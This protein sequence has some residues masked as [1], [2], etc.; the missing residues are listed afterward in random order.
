MR[1]LLDPKKVNLK[2]RETPQK[3][4][5]VDGLTEIYVSSANDIYELLHLGEKYRATASTGM[6]AQS[7]R[8]HSLFII[9]VQQKNRDGSTMTGRLNLADLAGSEKVGKTGATGDTLEEAKK[10][11]Q[12]L[13]Y[14]SDAN[15][16][17]VLW[18]IVL[19]RLQIRQVLDL[20]LIEVVSLLLFCKNLLVVT[21]RLVYLSHVQV[22][23]YITVLILIDSSIWRKPY[24]L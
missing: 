4:V 2:V 20:H 10:I 15:L 17:L 5:W 1:D 11:N 8:S 18:V 23:L 3:G 22:I 19:R 13:S 12:S 7:S 24:Q 21:V 16:I 14:Y 9:D 6:N